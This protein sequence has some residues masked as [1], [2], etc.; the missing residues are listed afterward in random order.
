M[1]TLIERRRPLMLSLQ[2][3]KRSARYELIRAGLEGTALALRA[4]LPLANAQRGVI[5]ALH[6]VDPESTA[7]WV[8]NAW[9]SI[10]PTFLEEAIRVAREEGLIPIALEEL[11]ERLSDPADT[12]RYVCFTLDDGYRDNARFAAPVFRRQAVPYTIFLTSGFVERSRSI[13]WKTAQELVM[14]TTSVDLSPWGADERVQIE[15]RADRVGLF[16]RLSNAVTDA[17]DE[18]AAV[19]RLD[20][21]AR[22]HGIDPLAITER[23]TMDAG[24]LAEL[25]EDPLASFGAHTLTHAN[26]R[27][28]SPQR[29]Q[30]EM[31]H[32][33]GKVRDYVGA[34]P[35]TFAYPYGYPSAVGAREI[36]AARE[37]GFAAA[38]TTEP[39]LLS[40]ASRHA[41]TALPRVSLNGFY[42][43]KRYVRALLSG[44]PFRLRRR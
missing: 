12:R 7:S 19:A 28:V 13:W 8:P 43:R 18:D 44:L 24:A 41:Q 37:A 11:P 27:K 29:L 4:G 10:T 16:D 33:A 17:E 35:A 21:L 2:A 31:T 22:A 42:Q 9:L 32:S 30:H 5:F 14:K 23:L 38:V 34:A 40:K 26:L 25:A 1:P 6:H 20:A 36:A 39:G 15:G 3:L